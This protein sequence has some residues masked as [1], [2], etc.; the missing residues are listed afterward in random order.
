MKATRSSTVVCSLNRTAPMSIRGPYRKIAISVLGAVLTGTPQPRMNDLA[1]QYPWRKD[2]MHKSAVKFSMGRCH[3]PGAIHSKPRFW[4]WVQSHTWRSA[5]GMLIQR[6][7]R[8]A[9]MILMFS[10]IE[11]GYDSLGCFKQP[12]FGVGYQR[13]LRNGCS[14]SDERLF[15]PGK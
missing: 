8:P 9:D 10:K 15:T 11:Q 3:W 12:F 5:P 1:K 6:V 7:Y 13:R 2:R 4:T 14:R